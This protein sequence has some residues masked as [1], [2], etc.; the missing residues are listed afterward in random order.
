MNK[1][2]E[3][4]KAKIAKQKAAT[5]ALQ[6]QLDVLVKIE[7]DTARLKRRAK[8]LERKHDYLSW[9][10]DFDE[11]FGPEA[12]LKYGFGAAT[13]QLTSTMTLRMILMKIYARRICATFSLMGMPIA[14]RH[15]RQ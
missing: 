14:H 4:L 11:W 13:R 6:K 7:H 15:G 2:I 9:E 10:S 8:R 5:R 12:M 1:T 3:Q